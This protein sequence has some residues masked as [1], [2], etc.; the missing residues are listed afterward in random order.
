[1]TGYGAVR[2]SEDGFELNIQLKSVNNR[3]LKIISKIPE[4]LSYLQH[5][6]EEEIR[7]NVERGSILLTVLFQPTRFTDLYEIDEDVLNKY[8]KRLKKLRRTTGNKEEIQLK[9][10]LLLP[11]VIHSEENVILGKDV[12]WPVARRGLL[13]AL[14]AM[15]SMRKRE[16]QSLHRDFTIREKR[17][18]RLISR[19]AA[20]APRAIAEYQKRLGD[21]VNRLLADREVALTPQDLAREIA[22]LAERSDITEEL[23]RMRSHLDQFEESLKSRSPVGRKLEFLIQEMLRESNTMTSK[24]LCP[25]MSRYLLEIKVEVDRLKEQVQNVE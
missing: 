5:D 22:V 8:Q 1:M 18:R 4:E 25:D 19:V 9:D 16:G 2:L 20:R 10:L 11:G 13:S 24:S 21:R 6:L 23:D 12:V 15:V 17:L 14:K 3:F 7:R